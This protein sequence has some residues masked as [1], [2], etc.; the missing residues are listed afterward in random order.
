VRTSVQVLSLD[1]VSVSYGHVSAVQDVTLSIEPGETLALIGPNGAG[2]STLLRAISN[3]ATKVEGRVL[4]HGRD[5]S[6]VAPNAITRAGVVH[7]P[8]GR[9]V[10]APLTVEENLQLAARASRR[11]PRKDVRSSIDRVY[12]LFPPLPRLRD[13]P[14]G[15][16]SGGEQQMVAI[17]RALMCRPE[18][19]LLDEPSMGLAPVMVEVIYTFLSKHR[20]VLEG[21]A[22]LL[23]EQSR[24]A[25]EVSDRA[26][27][28][29]R[30][31]L[32]FTGP[33]AELGEDLLT[34]AYLG[35]TEVLGHAI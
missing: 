1:G 20:D 2:K 22:I 12:E 34:S 10:V 35:T 5:I 27:V 3:Q 21:A 6:A 9:Q 14:S 23:A 30:G 28:L 26:A 19:L 33:V 7:V 13:K 25:L 18:V 16:L 8:E 17:G 32:V 4:L 24:V 15:L 11:C 29:S 31:A